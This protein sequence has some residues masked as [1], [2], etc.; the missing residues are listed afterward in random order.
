MLY[1]V[2]HYRTFVLLKELQIKCAMCSRIKHKSVQLNDED[3]EAEAE[4]EAQREQPIDVRR[5][6][7]P[8]AR[9]I[10]T[11]FVIIRVIQHVI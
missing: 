5:T 11:V 6:L 1:S 7:I 2:V 9:V 3:S 8:N 10:L 4:A